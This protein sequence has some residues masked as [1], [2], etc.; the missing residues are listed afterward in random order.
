M[1]RERSPRHQAEIRMTRLAVD[2]RERGNK[3]VV[4]KA[5]RTATEPIHLDSRDVRNYVSYRSFRTM[6]NDKGTLF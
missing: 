6:E 1:H 4:R 3:D 5:A 2:S